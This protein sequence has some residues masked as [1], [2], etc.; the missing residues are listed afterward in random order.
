MAFGDF[1]GTRLIQYCSTEQIQVCQLNLLDLEHIFYLFIL[2]Y[3]NFFIIDF[4][5]Q[6]FTLVSVTNGPV[7]QEWQDKAIGEL[8]G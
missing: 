3:Y 8:G 7:R 4:I 5:D 6:I 2:L 1:T